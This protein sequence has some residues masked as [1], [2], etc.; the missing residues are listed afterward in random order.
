M[1]ERPLIQ[2]E[3]IITRSSGRP[4]SYPADYLHTG[5]I[6]NTALDPSSPPG[7]SFVTTR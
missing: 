5:P 6:V 1:T 2:A 4:S 3:V 7:D